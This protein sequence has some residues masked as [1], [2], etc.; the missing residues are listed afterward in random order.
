MVKSFLRSIFVNSLAILIASKINSDLFVF[1][2]NYKT[3]LFAGL[4]IVLI[5]IL[6]RPILNLL[7]LPI[8]IVTLGAFRWI[9]NLIILYLITRI[10]PQ[11]S[12]G[13]FV[14]GPLN[15]GFIIVPPVYF[16]PFGS[17]LL[18]SFLL[19]LVFHLLYWLFEV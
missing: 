16:N 3:L 12:I 8:H 6:V 4:V 9:T 17:Y 13:S 10:V 15:L 5:N 7:L 19:S 11:F 18:A 2:G 1:T 14:S